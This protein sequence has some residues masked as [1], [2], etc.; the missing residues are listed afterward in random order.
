MAPEPSSSSS[1]S[2]T[3]RTERVIVLTTSNYLAWR[4]FAS[5][6]LTIKGVWKNV[7]SNI[8][9]YSIKTLEDLEKDTTELVAM[10]YLTSI[11]SQDVLDMFPEYYTSYT[12]FKAISAYFQDKDQF[13]IDSLEDQLND[14]KFKDF[15][16]MECYILALIHLFATLAA[17]GSPKSDLA[18]GNQLL[19]GLGEE[20]FSFV[21]SVRYLPDKE[22][23]FDKLCNMAKQA[24]KIKE[25]GDSS[26]GKVLLSKRKGNAN[27]SKKKTV[28]CY[29][30]GKSGHYKRDCRQSFKKEG[31]SG[32]NNS[33]TVLMAKQARFAPDLIHDRSQ[34]KILWAF[35]SG[36]SYHI[37]PNRGDFSGIQECHKEVQLPNGD[38]IKVSGIGN[39]QIKVKVC[40]SD[41]IVTLSNV[42]YIPEIQHRLISGVAIAEKGFFVNFSKEKVTV[43]NSKNEILLEGSKSNENGS[44]FYVSSYI[45]GQN[46]NA[47]ISARDAHQRMAHLNLPTIKR[48]L[49]QGSIKGFS[50]T[51]EA[52]K[53]CNSCPVG[54]MTKAPHAKASSNPPSATGELLAGD[55]LGPISVKSKTGLQYVSVF[56]DVYSKWTSIKCLQSPNSAAV[57]SHLKEVVQFLRTQCGAIIKRVRTDNAS[58][59]T[60]HNFDSYLLAEGI[61]H[62]L[63]APYS[64]ADNPDPERANR[65]ILEAARTVIHASNLSLSLWPYAVDYSVYT[66]NRSPSS[67]LGFRTPFEL[68]YGRVPDL[69]H[70]RDFGTKCWYRVPN[71]IGKLS[72]RGK[73]GIFL[74]Y[75]PNSS[76]YVI[77]CDNRIVQSRDVRF[78]S[79]QKLGG[80]S[81]E[82]ASDTSISALSTYSDDIS[83][84]PSPTDSTPESPI[85]S[86]FNRALQLPLPESPDLRSTTASPPPQDPVDAIVASNTTH[87]YSTRSK[88]PVDSVFAVTDILADPDSPSVTLALQSSDRAQW[89]SAIHTELQALSDNKTYVLV[90]PKAGQKAIGC[91]L[92][93]K[94][95]RDSKGRIVKYKARLCAQGFTQRFGVDYNETMA[96]VAR[97]TTILTMITL[98]QSLGYHIRQGDINNAFLNA[99][100]SETIYMRQPAGF[101]VA[102]KTDWWYLLKKDLYGLKQA[103]H[104][105]FHC[106]KK[107]IESLGWIQNAM[108]TCFFTK[109]SGKHTQY[110]IVYVDDITIFAPTKDDTKQS[111]DKIFKLFPGKDLGTINY[112]LGVEVRETNGNLLLSQTAL[113]ERMITKFLPSELNP[114]S[115]PLPVRSKLLISESEASEEET[116]LYQQIVGSLLHVSRHTR[117]DISFAT[118]LLGR[119]ASNPN[120]SHFEAAYHVLRYL[121]GTTEK[122]LTVSSGDIV[123]KGYS[124]ADWASDLND[125]KS[126]LGFAIYIGKN[127]V[128]WGSKKQ[129]SVALSTMEAELVGVAEATKEMLWLKQLLESVYCNI[130]KPILFC[131]NQ[132]A[133][134]ISKHPVDFQRSKHIDIKYFFVRNLISEG[135]IVLEKVSSVNNTADI[136]TKRLGKELHHAHCKSLTLL[137]VSIKGSV[138]NMDRHSS[139]KGV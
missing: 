134:T 75:V 137:D 117:P 64:S 87:R 82:S 136:F 61:D 27:G 111:L 11:I 93:L 91:K 47:V 90:P 89:I 94:R 115:T 112:L 59:Y 105:W 51:S 3:G 30:C 33:G 45:V 60:S 21:T 13:E 9:S 95:K 73:E 77:L 110:L 42:H 63:S 109:I 81:S 5:G 126:T 18:K 85:L 133:I 74:G 131:D 114:V 56:K 108:D 92:V 116:R 35:D 50:L 78:S 66:Q 10:S 72:D 122:G 138:K 96:P 57:L 67:S 15:E 32:A 38:N 1:S 22:R 37:S 55:I 139:N 127:L 76:A 135:V 24:Y 28:T 25:K 98:A 58:Y 68:I 62:H 34:K 29:N 70:L 103:G 104:D 69:S 12:L 106:F 97:W 17:A 2:T 44:L 4:R 39:I 43:L 31:E 99:N 54:K 23:T 113:L 53:E 130:P 7:N 120:S 129:K 119:F 86:S 80:K 20:W 40:G 101:E 16:N 6:Y 124:D 14:T 49:S 102:G 84:S 46:I 71:P 36:A 65:T 123:L 132:A 100:L 107:G 19:K 8:G 118:G 79:V 88:G 41:S 128:S 121:K 52:P 83:D 26:K 125:R 48:G